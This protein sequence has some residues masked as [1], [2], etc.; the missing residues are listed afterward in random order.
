[1][2]IRYL[3]FTLRRCLSLRLKLILMHLFIRHLELQWLKI[4]WFFVIKLGLRL[5]LALTV[6]PRPRRTLRIAVS[7]SRGVIP[8]N[9]GKNVNASYIGVRFAI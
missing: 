5:R 7:V 8:S 9:D 2:E 6:T 4:K 1:V 3:I